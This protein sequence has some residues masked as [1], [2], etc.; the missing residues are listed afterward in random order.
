MTAPRFALLLQRRLSRRD[1]PLLLVLA[2]LT[3]LA[4]VAALAGPRLLADE[5]DRA[6]RHAVAAEGEDADLVV[7][8][9]VGVTTP[10]GPALVSPERVDQREEALRRLLPPAL[11]RVTAAPVTAVVGP[12]L[13][14]TPGDT[15]PALRNGPVGV[16]IALLPR[17]DA[18]R[19]RSGAL[20]DDRAGSRTVDVVLSQAAA[21]ATSLRTGSVVDVPPSSDGA[22]LRLRVTGIVDRAA[23]TGPSPWTDFGPLWT[24][25]KNRN[26]TAAPLQIT[27]LTDADGIGRATEALGPFPAL[28]RSR[29]LPDRLTAAVAQQAARSVTGLQARPD[30]LQVDG[31][32]QLAVRSS[33]PDVVA[34]A[35]RE[36]GSARAQFLLLS[37]GVLGTAAV[38]LV[39]LGGLVAARRRGAVELQRARGATAAAIAVPALAESAAVVL[40][41]AVAAALVAGPAAP[42]GA[43]AIALVALLATPLQLA[44]AARRGAVRRVPANRSDRARLVRLRRSRRLAAEAGLVA[45]AVVALA[46]LDAGGGLSGARAN[47]LLLVAPLVVA[48][49]ATVLVLRLVPVAT[50]GP[51]RLTRRSRGLAGVLVAARAGR[52]GALLPVLALSIATGLALNDGLL[53]A[54]VA[55]GQEAAAWDRVGADAR[56]RGAVDVAPVRASAG[57]RAASAVAELRGTS[58][59]LAT[60][61]TIVTLLAVDADYPA[62]AAAPPGAPAGPARTLRRLTERGG[63]L[64]VVVDETVA[65]SMVGRTLRLQLD[66]GE[67]E[68]RAVG[69]VPDGPSGWSRG[70]Y[71]FVDL[72]ALRARAPA[73]RTTAALVDGPGAAAALQRA[74]APA[75]DV[76]T[77]TAWL[78]A[79][80]D[81]PLVAGT[82]T[83]TVLAA[84]L[85][86]L[87]AAFASAAAVLAGAPDRRRTLGLLRT[88]GT[89]RTAGWWLLLADLLPLVVGGIAGGAVVGIVCAAVVD[90]ALALAALTGGRADPPIVLSGPVLATVLAGLVA[91][92]AVA[93]GTEAVSWR[94][95]RFTEVLR[96]GGR[97]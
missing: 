17:A 94:R 51:A 61:S 33:L 77:R 66:S 79:R 20:P 19:L 4:L 34:Q 69:T 56:V 71:V 13:R 44:L 52:A 58:V 80:R 62:V 64:P 95:D 45:L 89:R 38:A 28:L 78:Q 88:L 54:S 41:A 72:D 55:S 9:A 92:L 8:T 87:L 12:D 16:R 46:V 39:L 37:A 2:L 49:A 74:G 24:P 22:A 26:G 82:R 43:V 1:T 85:L 23:G 15:V 6:V 30:V 96:V 90:P 84:A 81:A 48:A 35:G 47:P 29:L 68:A 5:L 70:P 93:V 73:I 83:A 91:V 27:V 36:A 76:L 40:A 63:A 50:R 32:E 10:G 31:G 86:A 14:L 97:G 75:R 59:D 42:P 7:R 53:A 3:A 67:V 57:V 21:D 60:T 25:R 18:I 65:R 11:R